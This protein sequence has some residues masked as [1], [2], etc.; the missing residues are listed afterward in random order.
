MT[1]TSATKQAT[2]TST[3]ATTCATRSVDPDVK[4]WI[5]V[6]ISNI[7]TDT[8]TVT[9]KKRQPFSSILAAYS[10]SSVGLRNWPSQL[11]TIGLGSTPCSAR[12]RTS[13]GD[14]G[15]IAFTPALLVAFRGQS[16]EGFRPPPT[17]FRARDGFSP[18]LSLPRRTGL[19][20]L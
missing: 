8:A 18:T 15:F 7:A 6:A 20:R 13:L 2:L 17:S 10:A 9:L 4:A 19:Q 14:S 11:R 12:S 3:M 16:G 1:P 5:N